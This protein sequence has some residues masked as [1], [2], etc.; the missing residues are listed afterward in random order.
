MSAFVKAAATALQQQPIVNA[1][2][3][4]NEIVYRD[5]VDISVAVSA[6][7]GLV[8]P[9]LRNVQT[10]NFAQIEKSIADYGKKVRIRRNF[11]ILTNFAEKYRPRTASLQWRTW[12]EE[13]LLFLTVAFLVR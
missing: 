1:V 9:V 13:L 4:G 12:Q 8:V 6:P 3:E 11:R 5:F 10:M 2:I 7:S